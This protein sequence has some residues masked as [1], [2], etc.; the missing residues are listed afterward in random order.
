[1]DSFAGEQKVVNALVGRLM[2]RFNFSYPLHS[3]V[4]QSQLFV[5]HVLNYVFASWQYQIQSN[6]NHSTQGELRRCWPDPAPLDDNLVKQFMVIFFWYIRMVS[7]DN[8]SSPGTSSPAPNK[9]KSYGTTS[10]TSTSNKPINST[11]RASHVSFGLDFI[12]QHSTFPS[13]TK[14]EHPRTIAQHCGTSNAAV[15]EMTRVVSRIIFFLTASNGPLILARLKQKLKK[16]CTTIEEEPDVLDFRLLEWMNVDRFRLSQIIQEISSCF[17]HLKKQSQSVIATSLRSAI[18]NWLDINPMEYNLLVESNRK[19]EGSPDHLFDVLYSLADLSSGSIGRKN[20]TFYPLMA[21][22]LVVCPDVFKKAVLEEG[23]GM[24]IGASFTKKVNWLESLRKGLGTAKSCETCAQVYIDL[25]NAAMCLSPGFESSGARSL[26]PDIQNDLKNALFYSPA[27]HDAIDDQTL[28]DGLVALYR[29]DPTTTTSTYFPRLLG[30]LDEGDKTIAIRAC[31]IIRSEDG[32]YPWSP[33]STQLSGTIGPNLRAILK[34]QAA[35]LTGDLSTRRATGGRLP[36]SQEELIL[37][38]L[39]LYTLDPT[40]LLFGSTDDVAQGIS[41]IS[42]LLVGPSPNGVRIVAC[43]TVVAVLEHIIGTPQENK[44]L[45]QSAIPS[46]WGLLI[47]TSRQ[48]LYTFQAGDPEDVVDAADAVRDVLVALSKVADHMPETL[49]NAPNAQAAVLTAM[50]AGLTRLISVDVDRQ[51]SLGKAMVALDRLIRLVYN[52]PSPGVPVG[53]VNDGLESSRVGADMVALLD[54]IRALPPAQGR[55]Q[56]HRQF[57]RV[58]R[59][60]AKPS[61]VF[62][63]TWTGLEM[64]GRILT[65]LVGRMEG[66][67]ERS[68]KRRSM[69]FDTRLD[70]EQRK[71][72]QNLNMLMAATAACTQYDPSSPPMAL[73]EIVGKNVLPRIYDESPDLSQAGERYISDS[74]NLLVTSSVMVR[75]SAK[76]LLGAELPLS[77]CRILT[78]AMVRLLGQAVGPNGITIA[79]SHTTFIDQALSVMKLTVDRMTTSEAPSGVPVDVG[80]FMLLLARY[81]ARLGRETGELRMKTRFC[82]LVE[83][84]LQKPNFVTFS[85]DM[86]F[87]NFAL[88]VMS[89]WAFENLRDGDGYSLSDSATRIHQELDHACL[90]AM[91]PVS[92]GLNLVSPGDEAAS[93]QPIVKSRLFYRHYH[94]LVRLLE[95]PQEPDYD[96]VPATPSLTNPTSLSMK[97]LNTIHA[98]SQAHQSSLAIAILSNLLSANIDV[99]LKACLSLGYHEDTNL[100]TAFMQL[101]TNILQQGARFG[102]LGA[103]RVSLTP[104]AYVESLTDSN[105]ALAMV[106]CD[107]CPNNE[108]DEISSL[109]F[110]VFEA[111]GTLLP[112][113]KLLI[114]REVA[115]TNHESELFRANSIT[116]RILTAV[117]KTYGYNYIRATLQPLIQSLVDK[118]ADCSFELDPSKASTTDD[119]ERNADHIRLLCQALL[120]LICS[121]T[122]RV[123]VV[124]RALC[125]YIWEVVEERFPDSR[126]S[127]VG[128]FIFLRFFCPAIVAPESIDLDIP[129]ENR[130]VRRALLL[131]TKVIQN[132]ANNVVFKEPHMR[133]LNSFLSENIRQVTKFLSDIAVRPRSWELGAAIK[134]T[135]EEA[136]RSQDLE[137]DEAILH[138]YIF[139][140]APKLEKSL[141]SLPPT[142]R[143]TIVPRSARPDLDARG[144]LQNLKILMETTGPPSDVSRLTATVRTQLY[145][146]FMKHNLGRSTEAVANVFY[147]GPASQNGMRIFYFV[148]SRVALIDYDLLAYHVFQQLDGITDYFDIVI[149]LTDFSPSTELPLAWLKRS[150]QMCPPGVFG[151]INTIALYNP[152]TYARKRVRRLI[153]ELLTVAPAA[154]KNVIAA[155]SPTELADSIPFTSLVLPEHTMALAYEADNVFTNLLCLTDHEMQVPVVVKLGHDCIQIASWRKTEVTS[156]LKSYIIDLIRLK[157]IDDIVTESGLAPDQLVIKHSQTESV[158]F[159]TRKRNDMAQILRAARARLRDVP[160][161][162]RALRPND[163]PGTLLNVAL[164]NLSAAD[165]TLRMGAYNLTHELSQFFKYDAAIRI[166]KVTAGLTIP[167]NSLSFTFNLSRALAASVPHLTLEFLKEWTIGFV[168]ASTPQKTACLNYVRPWLGNLEMF[169]RPSREDGPEAV[170]QVGDI[171]RALISITVSERRR[172]QLSVQEHVWSTLANAHETLVDIMINELLTA[173]IDAGIGSDKAETVGEILVSISSTAIRGK[174]I[175]RLRKTLAQTY[176]KPSASLEN[177]TAWGEICTL[178]RLNLSLSFAPHSPLDTQLFL[179]E[180]CHVLTLLVGVGQKIV[181]QTVYGIFPWH[182]LEMDGPALQNLLRRAQQPDMVAFFGLTQ[183][184]VGVELYEKAGTD[185]GAGVLMAVEGLAKFLGEVL[186][187][188]AVS[189]DCANAWRARW[190]GLVA[191]TCFQHNPATQPQAFTVL[192]YLASDELDDDLVYQI[193]VAMS[194]TLNHFTDA[195]HVLVIAMLRSLSC[196]IPG[197]VAETRYVSSLFWLAIAHLELGYVPVFSAALELILASLQTM[198]SSGQL[199]QGLIDGLMTGRKASGVG[200]TAGKLDQV[201][202]VSF[203]TDPAFSLVGIMVKGTRHPSTKKLTTETLLELLRLSVPSTPGGN[204]E[205]DVQTVSSLIAPNS[206]PFFMALLPICVGNE[207]EMKT[208]FTAAGLEVSDRVLGDMGSLQVFDLLSIPRDNSTAL[209]LVTLVVTLLHNCG[210]DTERLVLYRFLADASVEMP[211]VVCLT[212][213]ILVPRMLATLSTTSNMQILTVITQILERAMADPSYQFPST[214]SS[215]SQSSLHQQ[216]YSA[217]ISSTPS[218]GAGQREQVLED[219]GMKGLGEMGF[220]SV[221]P[222]RLATMAKWVATLIESFTI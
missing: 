211:E 131:I 216:G 200:E 183:T 138:R 159:I 218:V 117:A 212:Y 208:L 139:K 161:D 17:L 54:A 168:K 79:D 193:L 41:S 70:E 30:G 187:A 118:P 63:A 145:E 189:M 9:D 86:R 163:V 88:E 90:K 205:D 155:S 101:I 62:C 174:M 167:Q 127:A 210:S 94:N 31:L 28:V 202:G 143:T 4:V 206:V 162:Q 98:H 3:D 109:L 46:L 104:K 18:W 52:L 179:P 119:I 40:L 197:L 49:K 2:S 221:K 60:F 178:A 93:H 11:N 43:R 10:V 48:H 45:W 182:P 85:N 213:D 55:Q 186:A 130:E 96:H 47:D 165:E 99:G 116:T 110:R 1:M 65:G 108:V 133:V 151:C 128:S 42:S 129:P 80:E 32:Q 92:E 13:S 57:R 120:D 38:L 14:S 141:E 113:L 160:S 74:V 34:T 220:A 81:L 222:D 77:L 67:T 152:N 27:V 58:L 142:F 144:A 114:E 15:T 35:A 126:H 23:G 111:R 97:R 198:S 72:W 148:V 121:S 191:A 83:M 123:P 6:P 7:N 196:V 115:M 29:A 195:D 73:C 203:E 53:N 204:R 124:Y 21:M 59:Q 61:T 181:C 5:L 207:L 105:M 22:L 16:L 172:L 192:G 173:A 184:A 175:A 164:L 112:F 69:S 84:M 68:T 107:V 75:E 100:R 134:T 132:L 169:S 50:V 66:S 150:L 89:D 36:S 185:D 147:E 39:Q 199:N 87:R 166:V 102:G 219:L 156:S 214:I 76:E 176:L 24:K 56:Q 20:K 158:T 103:K 149:D 157:D 171:V 146:E 140:H 82:L 25:I 95:R 78:Q 37:E 125:H 8:T 33:P 91:V 137:G 194:T 190:M 180:I 170:K 217:S 154:G 51:A 215:E 64:R 188:G 106:I 71:E 209:L 122:P 136:E 26:V 44:M 177:N 201:A 153:A 135:Q 19:L 12:Q